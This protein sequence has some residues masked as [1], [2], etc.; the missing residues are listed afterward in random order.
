MGSRGGGGS[1]CIVFFFFFLFF[2][3]PHLQHMEIPRLGVELELQLLACATATVMAG[4]EPCL[5]LHHSSSQQ[6]DP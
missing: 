4:S 6:P 2:L 5:D 1:P 3:G